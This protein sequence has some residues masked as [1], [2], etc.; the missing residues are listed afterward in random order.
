MRD[1]DVAVIVVVVDFSGELASLLIIFRHDLT[2]FRPHVNK[3]NS[4]NDL[5]QKG[6]YLSTTSHWQAGAI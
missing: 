2:N 3:L 5:G 6:L 4:V 1:A